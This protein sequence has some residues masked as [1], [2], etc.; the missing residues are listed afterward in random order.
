MSLSTKEALEFIKEYQ[1]VLISVGTG[2]LV[3][4]KHKFNYY[5][6]K[7]KNIDIALKETELDL[8]TKEFL[9]EEKEKLHFFTITRIYICREKRIKILEFLKEENLKFEKISV[10]RAHQYIKVEGEKLKIINL[11]SGL[12]ISGFY[13]LMLLFFLW[14]FPFLLL[15]T[16]EITWKVYLGAGIIGVVIFYFLNCLIVEFFPV[17]MALKIKKIIANKN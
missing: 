16:K 14:Y 1:G 12:L 10:L 5:K 17:N 9:I 13:L 4:I 2:I 3:F 11:T 8:S 15:K 7:A 6:T